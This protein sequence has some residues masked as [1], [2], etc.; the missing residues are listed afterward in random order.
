MFVPIIQGELSRV[1]V[2]KH[3]HIG[4]YNCLLCDYTIVNSYV[5]QVSVIRA[6]SRVGGGGRQP[7]VLV[8]LRH[9][10]VSSDWFN[11]QKGARGEGMTNLIDQSI[12]R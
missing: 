9:D 12:T 10:E 4:V 8:M 6:S 5:I 11:N 3:Y 2:L 1:I 7:T